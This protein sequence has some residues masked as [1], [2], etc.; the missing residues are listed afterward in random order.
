MWDHVNPSDFFSESPFSPHP[1]V[2][3]KF[4]SLYRY[5]DVLACIFQTYVPILV[6]VACWITAAVGASIG[7]IGECCAATQRAWCL[8]QL[9]WCKTR[10]RCIALAIRMCA[11]YV[12]LPSWISF[13]WAYHSM[14]STW[15][16]ILPYWIFGFSC[17]PRDLC[18]QHGFL[19]ASESLGC[20]QAILSSTRLQRANP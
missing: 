2:L 17:Y 8:I 18:F 15:Y 20:L 4:S 11:S 12:V 6:Q 14:H 10:R 16:L 9:T 19:D 1:T 13:L 5:I 7:C 3:S